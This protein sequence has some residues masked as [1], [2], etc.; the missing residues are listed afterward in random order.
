MSAYKGWIN[1]LTHE[2]FLT[3]FWDVVCFTHDL[4]IQPYTNNVVRSFIFAS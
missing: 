2:K 1:T 4:I 3:K